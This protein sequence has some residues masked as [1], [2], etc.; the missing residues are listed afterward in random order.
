MVWLKKQEERARRDE[1]VGHYRQFQWREL[2]GYGHA[3]VQIS[4]GPPTRIRGHHTHHD[5]DRND[6]AQ[7]H[8][9]KRHSVQHY[10]IRDQV[11]G[12]SA[13]INVSRAT[14]SVH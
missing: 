2:T 11:P 5:V 12:Y 8:V 6:S 1:Q 14:S 7:Q 13:R 10:E 4:N 9:E 3:E